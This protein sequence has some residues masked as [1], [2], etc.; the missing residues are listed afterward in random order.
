MHLMIS[1]Y[2]SYQVIIKSRFA[3]IILV[4][5]QLTYHTFLR[6]N[7][8]KYLLT[9]RIHLNPLTRLNPAITEY[10]TLLHVVLEDPYE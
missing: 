6:K 9:S 8:S 10:N 4:V 2:D 5:S 3:H 1:L 7:G